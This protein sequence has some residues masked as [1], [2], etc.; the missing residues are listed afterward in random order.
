MTYMLRCE[1]NLTEKP[2]PLKVTVKCLEIFPVASLHVHNRKTILN[3]EE[4]FSMKLD[5]VSLIF[6]LIL[7]SK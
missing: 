6:M 1:T 3:P 7:C 4:I 5:S 2:L